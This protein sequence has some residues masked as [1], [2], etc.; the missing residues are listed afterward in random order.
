MNKRTSII[1]QLIGELAIPLL[2]Y[3]FWDWSLF[4]IL[5]FYVIENLF[6]L[7]FRIETVREVK[8]LVLR[9]SQ[10]CDINTLIKSLFLWLL[11]GILIH[12]LF[13]LMHPNQS[14]YEEWIR[15]FMYQDLGIPQGFILLPLLYFTSRLKMKQD[16]LLFVK[17]LKTNDLVNK[18]T[19]N[20]LPSWTGIS[21]WGLVIALN[22]FIQIHEL[23]NLS[24]ILLLI[25][26]RGFY[27]N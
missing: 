1:I 14:I 22:Y 24:L 9:Q 11:E 18:L 10:P 16:V 23:I 25:L 17:S 20:F 4:F 3:F 13:L 2:G 8:K 12:V 26:V 5:L 15:F 6:Y 7:F 21:L 19:V 27:K